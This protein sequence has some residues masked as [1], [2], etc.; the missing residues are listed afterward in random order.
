MILYG[1]YQFLH[2]GIREELINFPNPFLSKTKTINKKKVPCFVYLDVENVKL[3]GPNFNIETCLR[4]DMTYSIQVY[5][6]S[7][8]VYT[9]ESKKE[10]ES[11][12]K[13]NQTEIRVKQDLFF[14]EIP[15]MT[16]EGTFIISGC[17]RIIISQI[18]RSP[19]IYFRKEFGTNRK[20]IY[21]ATIISNRGVWT[22]IVL[23]QNDEK[24]SIYIKLNDFK[25]KTAETKDEADNNKLFIFDLLR[26]F[27]L[28]FQE[29][30][31]SVKYPLYL[32]L[33][34]QFNK[35]KY[36]QEI[37]FVL[38]GEMKHIVPACAMQVS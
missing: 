6:P 24:D 8:Y 32:N 4:R 36:I 10:L 19:G 34:Q 30:S 26:Y 22:K 35:S 38:D 37:K 2:T 31:D 27:G 12:E 20:A 33:Q 28:N 29:I 21:T 14:C 25:S 9:L 16:E 13:N 11:S 18:I 5:V 1:F 7:E 15:L 17:E 3:K 23:E